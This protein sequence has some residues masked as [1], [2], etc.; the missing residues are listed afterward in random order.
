MICLTLVAKL[1]IQLPDLLP[2]G[3]ELIHHLIILN[4]LL[5]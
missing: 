3:I 1:L 4:L 5:L 2:H